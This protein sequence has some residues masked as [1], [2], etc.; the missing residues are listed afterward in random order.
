[1]LACRL[2]SLD[3]NIKPIHLKLGKDSYTTNPENIVK[4]FSEQLENLYSADS[5]FSS[6]IV[7]PM[8]PSLQGSF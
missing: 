1:M 4:R 3:L 5:L 2:R 8:L 6:V 7:P